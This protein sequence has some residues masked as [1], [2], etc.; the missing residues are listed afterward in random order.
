MLIFW[1]ASQNGQDPLNTGGTTV[2]L[3][4]G[5]QWVLSPRFLVEAAFQIPVVQ[6][7]NGLQLAFAPTVNAGI[8][9]LF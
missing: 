2:F 5:V 1:R 8:R 9:I 7:L 6:D 4:P 3:A